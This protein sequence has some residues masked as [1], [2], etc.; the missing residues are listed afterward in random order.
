MNAPLVV[1]RQ[2]RH[3]PGELFAAWGAAAG[4]LDWWGEHTRIVVFSHDF[5]L[6]GAFTV[7]T[8]GPEGA[9]LVTTGSFLEIGDPRRVVFTWTRTPYQGPA[10]V[11]ESTVTVSFTAAAE[12]GEVTIVHEGLAAAIQ[13]RHA[14]GWA[15][16]LEGIDAYLGEIL[17]EPSAA[18]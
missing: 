3:A 10:E 7:E 5:R 16:A 1:S 11:A 6:G 18:R 15:R 14:V 12:G 2:F 9:G 17:P 8:N 13:S 4:L